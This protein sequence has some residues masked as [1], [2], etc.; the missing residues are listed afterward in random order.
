[1]II[2]VFCASLFALDVLRLYTQLSLNIFYSEEKDWARHT[3]SAMP[4][5]IITDSYYCQEDKRIPSKYLQIHG[6]SIHT[7]SKQI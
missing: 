3:A 4:S 1:M 5:P 7:I 2:Q 6:T